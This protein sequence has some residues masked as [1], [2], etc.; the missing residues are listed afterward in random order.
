MWLEDVLRKNW[1]ISAA[2]GTLV[3]ILI[4]AA[5]LYSSL[6]PPGGVTPASAV[7]SPPPEGMKLA[8]GPSKTIEGTTN[9]NSKT[10]N[11]INITDQNVS[12]VKLVLTWTDEP[13]KLL[14]ANQPDEFKIEAIA[15]NNQT[16][17]S[18]YV[19][20]QQGKAGNITLIA[21]FAPQTFP[22]KSGTGDW[23]I[24]VYAGNCGDWVGPLGIRKSSDTGNS[25]Q[26]T[27]S[28]TYLI[29]NNTR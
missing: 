9:E 25:W 11:T 28:Y 20:N 15:P 21:G 17:T 23:K 1:K 14:M 26:L 18:A 13:D 4:M 10:Q 16:N 29:A 12:Y 8:Q 22:D 6:N 7:I 3:I 27:I 19:P 2:I 24:N 5:I